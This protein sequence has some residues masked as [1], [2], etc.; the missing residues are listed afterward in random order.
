MVLVFND[1]ERNIFYYL[2]SCTQSGTV[3][4]AKNYNDL[5]TERVEYM[6]MFAKAAC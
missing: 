2:K 3:S 6:Y 4:Q 1:R 5:F